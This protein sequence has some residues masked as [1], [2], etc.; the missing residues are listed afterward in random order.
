[1]QLRF[2][3]PN[4]AAIVERYE[5]APETVLPILQQAL[6]LSEQ[7]LGSEK[8]QNTPYQTGRLITSFVRRPIGEL[9][10]AWGPTVNY[11]LWVEQGTGIYGPRGARIVPVRAKALAWM[12]GGTQF[13]RKST[14]GMRGREYM[15]KI[16]AAAT[17]Q[18]ESIFEQAEQQIIEAMS[19]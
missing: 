17:P 12:S 7:A 9:G 2:D 11:A 16:M 4:L 8:G 5:Q 18:L 15:E 6:N 10:F 14:A 1:M 13:I 3:I 19:L